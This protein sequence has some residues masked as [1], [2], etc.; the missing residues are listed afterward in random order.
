[1]PARN[2]ALALLTIRRLTFLFPTVCV[3]SLFKKPIDH[4]CYC[5]IIIYYN[6]G[7]IF[8]FLAIILISN[9]EIFNKLISDV[10]EHGN[11]LCLKG[12]EFQVVRQSYRFKNI[13]VVKPI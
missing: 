5:Y 3:W 8:V 10:R 11:C 2:Y 1:M 12:Q 13:S 4:Y 7:L 9:N 6:L